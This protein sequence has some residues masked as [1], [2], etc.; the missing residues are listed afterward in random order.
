MVHFSLVG[1]DYLHAHLFLVSFTRSLVCSHKGSHYF[2]DPLRV[3]CGIFSAIYILYLFCTLSI[4]EGVSCSLFTRQNGHINYT[5]HNEQDAHFF[6]VVHVETG[7][8]KPPRT[9]GAEH[10]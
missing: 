1:V 10:Q 8:V 7:L 2:L 3:L 9:L 4:S 6:H 5:P